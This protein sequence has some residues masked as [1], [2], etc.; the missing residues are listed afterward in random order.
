MAVSK[1]TTTRYRNGSVQRRQ[2]IQNYASNS[3]PTVLCR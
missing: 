2:D 3:I 1:T